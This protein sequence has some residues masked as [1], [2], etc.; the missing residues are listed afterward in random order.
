MLNCYGRSVHSRDKVNEYLTK[1]GFVLNGA[2][3]ATEGIPHRFS[4]AQEMQVPV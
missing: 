1:H 2:G 4:M 3:S